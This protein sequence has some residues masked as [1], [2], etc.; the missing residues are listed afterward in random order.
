MNQIEE[1]QAIFLKWF[2]H[3]GIRSMQQI[4]LNVTNICNSY[5]F[6]GKG[7]YWIFFPLVRKGFIEFIG[8]DTYQIAPT[9]IIHD[10][11]SGISTGINLNENQIHQIATTH[12]CEIETDEFCV[13][14]FTSNSKQTQNI[15]NEINCPFAY[16]N[17]DPI[18]TNFPKLSDVISGYGKTHVTLI[19]YRYL[20]KKH[21]WKEK[22]EE[23]VFGIYKTT[24]DAHVHYFYDGT[25]CF[26]IC[27][28]S[29]NPDSWNIFESHQA[30][31]EKIEFLTYNAETKE[32][33]LRNI[34]I[35]ILLDRILR[36]PSL[37]L[38]GSG[39]TKNYTTIYKN[40]SPSSVKQ[41][42]RIYETKINTS[43]G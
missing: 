40:I 4:R 20:L 21:S 8:D 15:C 27:E 33:I 35:P 22:A 37:H 38:H 17:I 12:S 16:S 1:I 34:N 18:L 43:N 7:L 41:L 14:R 36:I 5:E 23:V 24:L 26:E 10:H 30:I 9:V 32:L 42:N 2:K 28:R 6:V 11:Q 31:K 39:I 3:H 13:A 25:N 29:T 19:G